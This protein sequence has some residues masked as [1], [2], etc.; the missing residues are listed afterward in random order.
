MLVLTLWPMFCFVLFCCV[1]Q[2]ADSSTR[3]VV[4]MR[5]LCSVYRQLLDGFPK[6][7][8]AH[9]RARARAHPHTHAHTEFSGTRIAKI[10]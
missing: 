9:T 8:H 10:F 4:E 1:A 3:Q 2:W 7:T 5:T 6:Y